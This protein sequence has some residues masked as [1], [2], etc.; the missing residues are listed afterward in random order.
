MDIANSP[1]WDTSNYIHKQLNLSVNPFATSDA[2]MRPVTRICVN[3]SIV[4]NDTL[5][6]KGLNKFGINKPQLMYII[7]CLV[8]MKKNTLSGCRLRR[9]KR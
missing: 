8:G 3:F 1:S 5:V 6:A 9:K 7:V 2:F 4:Y